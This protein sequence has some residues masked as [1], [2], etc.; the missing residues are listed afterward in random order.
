MIHK[1]KY[2]E[3]IYMNWK[4]NFEKLRR[5]IDDE[6]ED[7]IPEAIANAQKKKS[8]SEIFLQKLKNEIEKLL[9][10]E[11]TRIPNTNKA[12]IPQKFAVYLG[13]TAYNSMQDEKRAF[14]EQG[15]GAIIFER[16]EEMVEN[17]E[18]TA[19]KI[20]V[21]IKVDATLEEDE[22]EVKAFSS[23][24]KQ[25]FEA[26]EPEKKPK[27]SDSNA[28]N[29]A[30]S[31]YKGTIEDIGTIED[32]DTFAGLLYRVEIW[33]AGKK[34]N[35]FPIIKHTTTIGRD[36]GDDVPNLRLVTDNRKISSKHAEI[37]Y[38]QNGEIWVKAL[39]KNPTFVSGKL[40]SNG[41]KAKL[42]ADGEIKIYD[43][44]LKI[45]KDAGE[46]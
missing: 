1:H 12:Y 34:L 24:K 23:D 43:F 40:I 33:E 46:K 41:E 37:Q 35:N 21:N 8:E 7:K 18:L 19:K 44:V 31:K 28:E 30:D 20:T 4:E 2:E 27:V 3:Q 5:W 11:I 14:F 38:E 32:F 26:F 45:K 36:G 13:E 16:A 17:L 29:S 6:Q 25:T 15:L 39:H 42:G 9:E 22:I 10:K